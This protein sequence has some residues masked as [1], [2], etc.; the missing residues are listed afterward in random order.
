MTLEIGSE[1]RV[2]AFLKARWLQCTV[3]AVLAITWWRG[4]SLLTDLRRLDEGAVGAR[5]AAE[6]EAA[7]Q[8]ALLPLTVDVIVAVL[9]VSTRV[10]CSSS[11]YAIPNSSASNGN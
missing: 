6:A 4:E 7:K 9:I 8:A 3:V 1:N 10:N 5:I 2:L 11:A